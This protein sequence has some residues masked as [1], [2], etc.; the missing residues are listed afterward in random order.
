MGPSHE[1][2][3]AQAPYEVVL[4]YTNRVLPAISG[5]AA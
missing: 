4:Q 2:L 1:C 3:A 5:P